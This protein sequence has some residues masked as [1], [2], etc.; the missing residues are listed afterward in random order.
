ML[1]PITEEVA[2]SS[3]AQR[4]YHPRELAYVGDAVFELHVRRRLLQKKLPQRERHRAAVAR[5]RAS[6]QAAVLRILEP[7]LNDTERAVTR[8]ARNN[9]GPVPRTIAQSTYRQAT[10]LEA[11][12]GHLYLQGQTDRLAQLLGIVDSSCEEAQ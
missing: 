5:V 1:P 11:L 7:L 4:H 9:K 2:A 3:S 12:L 6:A 8:R 10:A